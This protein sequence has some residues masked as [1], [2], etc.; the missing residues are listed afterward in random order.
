[1]ASV[2]VGQWT[3]GSGAERLAEGIDDDRPLVSCLMVT[4]PVPRRL[5]SLKRSLAGYCRQTWPNRELV[6]VL[7]EGTAE[8]RGAVRDAVAALGRSDIRIV[9]PAGPLALGALRNVSM[10]E[11][12]GDIICLWD[13]DDLFHPERLALQLTALRASG[14]P[15]TCLT[16]VMQYFPAARRLYLTN[17]GGTPLAVKPAAL[18]AL[19][20]ALIPYPE[21]GPEA[22]IGEDLVVLSEL[23]GRGGIHGQAGLPHLYVYVSHGL[24][25]CGEDHHQMIADRLAVSQGLLRRREAAVRE[26]LAP[27]EFGAGEVAV[28]GRNGPGFVIQGRGTWD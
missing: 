20:S 13:D 11:A 22:R 9:E 10:R 5:A 12:R 1:M 23:H 2:S 18:L 8:A 6:I 17:W 26:G 7:D 24:N 4:L 25:T 3:N 27:F 19:K 28:D 16:E 14:R 15:A 21:T